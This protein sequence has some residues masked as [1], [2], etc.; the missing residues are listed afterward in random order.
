MQRNW[1]GKL[2]PSCETF[3]TIEA[4]YGKEELQHDGN[5]FSTT[6]TN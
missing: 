2:C 3:V 6:W 1:K 5:L 4:D